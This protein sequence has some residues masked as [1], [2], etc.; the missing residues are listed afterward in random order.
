LDQNTIFA[1]LLKD[2][3][4]FGMSLSKLQT[5]DSKQLANSAAQLETPDWLNALTNDWLVLGHN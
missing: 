1:F 2:E 5:I 4:A 3:N